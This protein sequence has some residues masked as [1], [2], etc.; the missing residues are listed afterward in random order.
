DRGLD[1]L[2]VIRTGDGVLS[3]I[4]PPS[5]L[6]GAPV[7]DVT[8][9]LDPGPLAPIMLSGQNPLDRGGKEV[10]RVYGGVFVDQNGAVVLAQAAGGVGFEV[11]IG[12]QT[13]VSSLSNAVPLPAAGEESFELAGRRRGLY[14]SVGVKA[15]AEKAVAVVNVLQGDIAGLQTAILMV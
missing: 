4:A 3:S 13:L 7:I 14:T 6:P 10:L 1:Y 9:V 15:G 2:V 12:R 5:L 11:R 8:T